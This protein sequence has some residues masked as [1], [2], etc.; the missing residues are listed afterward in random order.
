MSIIVK[1]SRLDQADQRL[2]GALAASEL[3][4]ENLDS[5]IRIRGP[6]EYILSASRKGHLLLVR[7]RLRLLLACDCVRCLMEFDLR[8]EIGLWT[9]LIPLE[10]DERAKVKN[11]CVDLTPY[12][13]EDI[14][15]DFPLHPVCGKGCQGPPNERSLHKGK[16]SPGSASKNDATTWAKLDKLKF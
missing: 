6:L 5:A 7:G 4:M 3:N 12:I 9:R 15:L 8:V 10:G 13:R 16:G 11:D 1:L 14:L 2:E